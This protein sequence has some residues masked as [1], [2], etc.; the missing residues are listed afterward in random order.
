[1]HTHTAV[2][3]SLGE[4]TEKLHGS[5]MPPGERIPV[6]TGWVALLNIVSLTE[7]LLTLSLCQ[8][9]L[10]IILPRTLQCAVSGGP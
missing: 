1:M 9:D 2:A 4:E 3:R 10:F 8:P 6:S 5:Q 7:A